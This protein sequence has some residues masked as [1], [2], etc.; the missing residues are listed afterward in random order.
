MRSD[1]VMAD[2]WQVADLGD[3]ADPK[4]VLAGETAGGTWFDT[5]L[6]SGVH[7]IMLREGR[8]RD[9]HVGRNAAD[10]DWVGD[11]DWVFRKVFDTPQHPEGPVR[12]VLRGVDTLAEVYLNGAHIADLDDMFCEHVLDVTDGLNPVGQGNALVVA[13]RSASRFVDS[14]TVPEHHRGHIPARYHLRKGG[15]DFGNYLGARPRLVKT[16]IYRDVVL[17]LTEESWLDD[18][19]V[20]TTLGQGTA[21]VEVDVTAGGIA[22]GTL[23]WS[24]RGPDG[25]VV[26]DGERSAAGPS[27]VIG[28][29]NPQL[30]WPRGHGEQALYRLVVDLH[31]D[32]GRRLDTSE[33][34]VGLREIEVRTTRPG[35]DEPVFEF[36]VNGRQVFVRGANWAQVE[37][38]TNVWDSERALR[39][40]DLAEHANM[41]LLRV[42][43]GGLIPEPEFYAE[44]DRRG[45]L[46]WQDF[47]FEYGMYPT[48][49]PGYLATVERELID[50]VKRLRNHACIAL[51]CGG[52]ENHMGWDF[53]FHTPP[54]FGTELFEAVMPRVCRD[55]D[56]TRSYHPSS[57][58]GGPVAN[59]PRTGDWHDY[60]TVTYCHRLSVPA[61]VSEMGRVS[62]PSM[63]SMQ[64][65]LAPEDLWPADHDATVTR[66]GQPSW[67]PMWGY[68]A[69]D[70]AWAKIG[71]IEK[72]LE[73]RDAAGLVRAL[74]T[75]H[76]EY[77]QTSV[78]RH[79][80]GVPDGAESGRR[81]NGGDIVWRLNDPWP[82]LYWSV[83]D[84]YLEPKIAYY[85]L[86]RAY[87]PVLVSFEQTAD[88]L[89]V[90]VTND[91]PDPVVGDLTV[92]RVRFDG[93]VIGELRQAVA[94]AP[95]E[96]TR[97][98]DTAPLGPVVLRNEFLSA[99]L[100]GRVATHLLVGERYLELPPA[101]LTARMVDSELVISTDVFARQVVL[102]WDAASDG[103]R[104]EDNYFD[105]M[106]GQKRRIRLVDLPR[107]TGVVSVSALNANAVTPSVR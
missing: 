77:L 84:A 94:V 42:W 7:E 107:T 67:P 93:R 30:W 58:F 46:V 16:G 34:E 97:L 51:W 68:R 18:V 66:P 75:A 14:V 48:D 83:V 55:H 63:R 11:R 26:S 35:T 21:H 95:G 85:Y 60:T 9:P 61:F 53:Q 98:V 49:L 28:V 41:N 57:P 65:F 39:L 2:G 38:M 52:N 24:L 105:L 70:G 74:G 80:R 15:G 56:G 19:Q 12:L 102:D 104:V 76:G 33:V 78:E 6:P 3:W 1:V 20:R 62:T 72:Y 13:V 86:R 50:V 43:G 82:I 27:W 4:P 54:E 73:P 22:A 96:S 88:A 87:S 59:W 91:T 5:T 79:R 29:P 23:R 81:R 92:R 89:V 100:G 64:R 69:P 47:M 25:D 40:L 45:L 71:P 101:E 99:E 36:V 31:G 103:V 8:I 44:C 10:A 37:G 106:P 17:S 32:D 90:W